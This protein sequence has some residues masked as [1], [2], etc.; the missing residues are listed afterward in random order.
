MRHE[1]E[2]NSETL[3]VDGDD[4]HA[5][6][7]NIY[8]LLMNREFVEMQTDRNGWIIYLLSRH[9]VHV[10]VIYPYVKRWPILFA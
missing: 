8:E 2:I 1:E 10:Y 4:D 6:E 7:V 9:N 5:P 3:V